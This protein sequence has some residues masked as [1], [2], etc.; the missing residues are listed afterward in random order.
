[1]T[2]WASVDTPSKGWLK[3]SKHGET[4]DN[5]DTS[6]LTEIEEIAL[7]KTFTEKIQE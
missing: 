3:E 4:C 7:I 1:M 6:N 5:L 2:I